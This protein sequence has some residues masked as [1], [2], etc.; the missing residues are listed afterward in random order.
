MF[1]LKSLTSFLAVSLSCVRSL[2]VLSILT[3]PSAAGQVCFI[4]RLGS[5]SNILKADV[6]WNVFTILFR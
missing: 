3:L 4:Y 2:K 5:F 1:L 6:A